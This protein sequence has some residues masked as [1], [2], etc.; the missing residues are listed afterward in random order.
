MK[1][2]IPFFGV[3]AFF[4][5]DDAEAEATSGRGIGPFSC[6]AEPR[7]VF[8]SIGQLGNGTRTRSAG[9]P[10]LVSNDDL[11]AGFEARLASGDGQNGGFKSFISVSAEVEK[12]QSAAFSGFE[13]DLQDFGSFRL[14]YL[15]DLLDQTLEEL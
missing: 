1:A 12:A 11:I 13:L 5:V 10:V 2:S 4:L 7:G 8:P 6:F 3:G 9:F 14:K 15:L